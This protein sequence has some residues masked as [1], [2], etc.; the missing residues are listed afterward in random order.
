MELVPYIVRVV[1][2]LK[3]EGTGAR[4]CSDAKF[5]PPNKIRYLSILATVELL[6]FQ[7]F[8]REKIPFYLVLGPTIQIFGYSNIV[9]L[10]PYFIPMPNCVLCQIWL[11]Q[12]CGCPNSLVP[13]GIRAL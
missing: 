12:H 6:R 7:L 5:S 9:E 10:L 8:G 13:A 2:K 4:A 11:W 1:P 3:K